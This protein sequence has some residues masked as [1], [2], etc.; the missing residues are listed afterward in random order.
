MQTSRPIKSSAVS[1]ARISDPIE[2]GTGAV[3]HFSVGLEGEEEAACSRVLEGM[4]APGFDERLTM[5]FQ[6]C[7]VDPDV[8]WWLYRKIVVVC[9]SVRKQRE[10][11]ELDRAE[12]GQGRVRETVLCST[13]HCI[14]G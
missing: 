5:Q 13:C 9:A 12:R 6:V 4:R 11:S 1:V 14:F 8:P 2:P 7:R 3:L 10:E